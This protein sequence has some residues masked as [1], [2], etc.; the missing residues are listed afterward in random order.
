MSSAAKCLPLIQ[1]I[2]S[3]LK[4]TVAEFWQQLCGENLEYNY[5]KSLFQI[6]MIPR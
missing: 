1:I 6:Y 5:E 4:Q 2:L 3:K